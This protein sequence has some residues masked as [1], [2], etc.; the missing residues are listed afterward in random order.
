MDLLCF[1]AC[2]MTKARHC[3]RSY[4]QTIASVLQAASVLKQ[5]ARPRGPATLPIEL[6]LRL[7]FCASHRAL[8]LQRSFEPWL[9]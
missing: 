8:P 2:L 1:P 6:R 5:Q 7:V 9:L 4:A 3:R